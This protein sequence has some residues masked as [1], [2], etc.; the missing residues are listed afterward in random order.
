VVCHGEEEKVS[1]DRDVV[2][3]YGLVES[4]DSIAPAL[5]AHLSQSQG[6]Q[7]VSVIRS[8]VDGLLCYLERLPRMAEARVRRCQ[9]YPGFLN[10]K[11]LVRNA[12]RLA[13]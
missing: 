12:R 1:G 9:E 5:A 3:F 2:C 11:F 13:S 6:I 8:S 10:E 4:V 7:I